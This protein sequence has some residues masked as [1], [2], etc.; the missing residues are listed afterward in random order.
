MHYHR[1]SN[2]LGLLEDAW[3]FGFAYEEGSGSPPT[4]LGAPEIDGAVAGGVGD[5]REAAQFLLR[6]LSPE[7]AGGFRVVFS[8]TPT[9]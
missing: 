1:S 2:P 3:L 4:R 5:D 8:S 9:S 6:V 7:F